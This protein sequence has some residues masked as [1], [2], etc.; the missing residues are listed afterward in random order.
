MRDW[1]NRKQNG[2]TFPVQFWKFSQGSKHT[3][4]WIVFPNYHGTIWRTSDENTAILQLFLKFIS[5][6]KWSPSIERIQLLQQGLFSLVSD[7]GWQYFDRLFH[8]QP[9]GKQFI[10]CKQNHW[11]SKLLRQ[12]L[13]RDTKLFFRRKNRQGNNEFVFIVSGWQMLFSAIRVVL[14]RCFNILKPLHYK[15]HAV[16]P[17]EWKFA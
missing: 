7:M 5:E 6:N 1:P 11:M 12:K 16:K 10:D 4:N 14:P 15:M 3:L 9:I 17:L 13:N 8:K 2:N